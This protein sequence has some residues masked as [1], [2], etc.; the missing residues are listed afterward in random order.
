MNKPSSFKE[1]MNMSL[2]EKKEELRAYRINTDH[3]KLRDNQERLATIK[4][5]DLS[6]TTDADLERMS[7]LQKEVTESLDKRMQ[8]IT[9]ELTK[10]VPF[11][12]PNLL[13]FGACT[14]KGK[15]TIA[16]N[17][18]HSLYKENKRTLILSN[19]EVELSVFNRVASLELG[20]NYNRNKEFSEEQ[21]R[22]LGEVRVKI[23]S[24]LTVVDLERSCGGTSAVEGM[25]EIF[26]KLSSGEYQ[27]DCVIIDYYQKVNHSERTKGWE[28]LLEFTNLLD[29]SYKTIKAPIVVLAQLNINT[30]LEFEGR[31]KFGRSI[32]MASTFAMEVKADFEKSETTWTCHKARFGEA[33][34]SINTKWREGRYLDSLVKV[35]PNAEQTQEPVV[36]EEKSSGSLSEEPKPN[37]ELI[38]PDPKSGGP[39][40]Q[41]D[42][43][44]LIKELDTKFSKGGKNG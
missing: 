16:A 3:A 27:Y 11:H 43:D 44:E 28:T 39:W 22:C 15:S 29:K 12:Y 1:S 33:G 21:N 23:K 14:G 35:P 38:K 34:V 24:H 18:A 17:I 32:I 41:D 31:I 42:F 5:I 37:V 9:P 36:A 13:L 10:I 40:S 2:D 4:S 25:R 20:Y 8:F 26:E 7:S 6:Y 30:D 19:E